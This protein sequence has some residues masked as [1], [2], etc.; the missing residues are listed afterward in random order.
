MR[1][2]AGWPI[3]LATVLAFS[4]AAWAQPDRDARAL[5]HEGQV[6]YA[7]GDFEQAIRAFRAAYARSHAPGLL[8][9][10]AQACRLKGDRTQA[11]TYYR[12]YLHEWP[13]A[14]NR[15]DAEGRIVELELPAPPPA[16][17]A[18]PP[19]TRAIARERGD[20]PLLT[21]GVITALTGAVVLGAGIGVGVDGAR[22]QSQAG[23]AS[24]KKGSWDSTAQ[25][26]YDRGQR[27]AVAGTVLDVVGGAAAAA[28][29]VMAV[30]GARN[31]RLRRVGVGPTHRGVS[32]VAGWSF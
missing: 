29:T 14:P 32:V 9:N 21:A 20:H 1:S 19:T 8:F 30:L 12:A 15:A 16:V 24:Q 2:R 13:D 18:P 26:S 23:A 31:E 28:G 11:L 10:L 22:M 17:V 27:E 6:S 7:T 5:F 25:A 3:W 4:P